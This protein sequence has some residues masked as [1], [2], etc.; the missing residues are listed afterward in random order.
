MAQDRWI[1]I[2]ADASTAKKNDATEFNHDKKLG[3]AAGGDLTVSF[4][5]AK[6]VSLAVFKSALLAAAVQA[7]G[8]MKP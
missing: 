3:T 2:T 1:N 7:A 8:M 4:D 6:F 5:S